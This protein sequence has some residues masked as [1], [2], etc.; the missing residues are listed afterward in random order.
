LLEDPKLSKLE[1]GNA[2]AFWNYIESSEHGI[3]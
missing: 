3:P 2:L 1:E